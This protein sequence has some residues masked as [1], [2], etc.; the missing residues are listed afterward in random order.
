MEEVASLAGICRLKKAKPGGSGALLGK[1]CVSQG[2]GG[3]EVGGVSG[4][5]LA[6]E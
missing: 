1:R 2:Q 5:R 3:G 6:V 4:G